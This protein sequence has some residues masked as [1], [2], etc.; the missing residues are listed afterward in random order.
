[1][2]AIT[3]SQTKKTHTTT[4]Q[5]ATK[6]STK[7]KKTSSAKKKTSLPFMQS[8]D[9]NTTRMSHEQVPFLGIP[10]DENEWLTYEGTC[11]LF[12]G[13]EQKDYDEYVYW[14]FEPEEISKDKL[15]RGF[16]TVGVRCISIEIIETHW[17]EGQRKCKFICLYNKP[18]QVYNSDFFIK[19]LSYY[20][21]SDTCYAYCG[22]L[23]VSFD[24]LIE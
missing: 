14:E 5:D 24:R 7:P 13:T 8:N 12:C 3:R 1:M 19:G 23:E 11:L 15:I 20:D 2:P 16:E 6:P 21:T 4:P 17:R 9:I 10:K 18:Y 22:E